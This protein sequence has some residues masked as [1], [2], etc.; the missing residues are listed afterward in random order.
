M[1]KL[2]S[3]SHSLIFLLFI[4]SCTNHNDDYSEKPCDCSKITFYSYFETKKDI[5]DLDS[6]TVEKYPKGRHLDSMIS[7]FRGRLLKKKLMYSYPQQARKDEWWWNFHFVDSLS[8]QYDYRLFLFNNKDT[9]LY[10]LTKIT[11]REVVIGGII[12]PGETQAHISRS[13]LV[14]SVTVNGKV[15]FHHLGQSQSS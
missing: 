14:D 6:I 12:P 10:N 4:I 7:R 1:R 5:S 11:F 15:N 9:L 13:C 3:I 2:K 8:S